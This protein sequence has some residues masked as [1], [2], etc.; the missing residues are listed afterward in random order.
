MAEQ[1]I[2]DF[3]NQEAEI[4]LVP[5]S[6]LLCFIRAFALQTVPPTLKASLVPFSLIFLKIPNLLGSSRFSLVDSRLN[7]I[8]H[9]PFLSFPFL[10]FPFLSF[11]FLSFP[12]LSFF[13]FSLF[14]SLFLS[15]FLSI[16][17]SYFLLLDKYN[18]QVDTW[19]H[20]IFCRR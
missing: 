19:F 10:S 18:Y 5:T 17:L 2:S 8:G 1:S 6:F 9:L 3:R 15:V 16:Y 7:I 12:F 11:P 13:L 4:M 20:E 14:L